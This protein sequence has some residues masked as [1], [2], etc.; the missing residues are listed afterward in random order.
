MGMN[1]VK[2]VGTGMSVPYKV[3]TNQELIDN[4]KLD[5]T[6][7]WIKKNVGIHQRRISTGETS[8]SLGVDAIENALADTFLEPED[9]DILIVATATPTK[10][11]PST[12]CIIKDVLG[13]KNAVAFDVAAVCSGFLFGI[14]IANNYLKS[15][16]DCYHAVVVGVDV[17]STI[18][19]WNHKHS[20]FFG[21]GAGAFILEKSVNEVGFSRC[22]LYSDS[23]DSVGFFCNHGEKF[24]M[25][26]RSVYDTA[27]RVLPIAINGVL[28]QEY[29]DINQI[30][31]LVPH[32]P[33]KRILEE[34]A[35]EILLPRKKLLM[36]M[37]NYANTV[38]ATIP[39]LYHE[40]KEM[41]KSGDNI[42]FAAIGSGWTYGS[43]I[44]VV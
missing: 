14:D 21:D 5:T 16:S 20:I 1:T 23:E 35:D 30:D 26:A 27:T 12:A 6:D 44:Y 19:D 4:H 22:K 10:I 38:A 13:M 37:E 25:N 15:R 11:S 31:Y 9:I 7:E 39:I 2:I 8:A 36:N 33:S 42:L 18:T 24:T 43:A 17:F 40:K 28:E 29:M 41:F 32:Q 3:V 34:V